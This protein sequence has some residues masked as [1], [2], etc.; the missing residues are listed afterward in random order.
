MCLAGVFYDYYFWLYV[1]FVHNAQ[2]KGLFVRNI[3]HSISNHTSSPLAQLL[4]G[5][6]ADI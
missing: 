4:D 2:V 1:L 5:G 6:I 3:I